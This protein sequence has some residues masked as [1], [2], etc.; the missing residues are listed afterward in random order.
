MLKHDKALQ[1]RLFPSSLLPQGLL[2]RLSDVDVFGHPSLPHLSVVLY[3]DLE[4]IYFLVIAG[5]HA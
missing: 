2:T 3:L 1:V 5:G 4:F